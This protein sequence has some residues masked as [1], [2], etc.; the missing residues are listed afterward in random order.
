MLR[1]VITGKKQKR[2]EL[3]EYLDELFEKTNV[4][5][6]IHVTDAAI[7]TCMVFE[8]HR[9]HIHFVDGSDGGYVMASRQLKEQMKALDVVLQN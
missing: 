8:Y 5:Y 9:D 3:E 7:V 6:G 1:V 4:A 2:E